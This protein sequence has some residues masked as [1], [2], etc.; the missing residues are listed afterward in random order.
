[1]G[2][3]LVDFELSD[4]YM[5]EGRNFVKQ[6]KAPIQDVKRIVIVGIAEYLANKDGYTIYESCEGE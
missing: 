5:T 6:T 1:M 2:L 4:K 3:K